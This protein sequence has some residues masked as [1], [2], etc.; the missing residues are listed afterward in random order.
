MF[1][2]VVSVLA[3][4]CSAHRARLERQGLLGVRRPP[5][6]RGTVRR[7]RGSQDA[8]GSQV[9][10][11]LGLGFR[12]RSGLLNPFYTKLSCSQVGTG[13][14]L[15]VLGAKRVRHIFFFCVRYVCTYRFPFSRGYSTY[16]P[17]KGD[18]YCPLRRGYSTYCPLQRG[19][20][21]SLKK[22][23]QYLLSLKRGYLLSH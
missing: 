2:S 18:T 23:L 20:L 12:L 3:Y 16:C 1:V 9:G 19:Y 21:L 15:S 14:L 13:P 6:G 4:S 8:P 5:R 10:H 17:S 22:G 11:R 7:V